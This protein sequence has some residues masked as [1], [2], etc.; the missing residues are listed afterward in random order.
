MPESKDAYIVEGEAASAC[1]AIIVPFHRYGFVYSFESNGFREYSEYLQ[2]KK[3]NIRLLYAAYPSEI[4]ESE[5]LSF[6]GISVSTLVVSE[7][8]CSLGPM[9]S[10]MDRCR[11]VLEW[12]R[13]ESCDAI[14]SSS[15]AGLLYYVQQSKLLNL[16]F[17]RTLI[18][19][20]VT[21]PK[22]LRNELDGTFMSTPADVVEGWLECRTI[23]AADHVIVSSKADCHWLKNKLDKLDPARIT[24]RQDQP[25]IER[26]VQSVAAPDS[27]QPHEFVFIEEAYP[28]NGFNHLIKALLKLDTT[29]LTVNLVL[30]GEPQYNAPLIPNWHKAITDHGVNVRI[31]P[32]PAKESELISYLA[33]GNRT[34]LILTTGGHRSRYGH[35]LARYR[36]RL[37]T[38]DSHYQNTNWPDSHTVVCE[39]SVEALRDALQND[40]L[41]YDNAVDEPIPESADCLVNLP[42]RESEQ[43]NVNG[44]DELEDQRRW[45]LSLIND[46]DINDAKPR[47]SDASDSSIAIAAH[48]VTVCISHYCRPEKL[49]T[50]LS[51]LV[52]QTI[53]GFEVIVVDDGSE[54]E[55]QAALDT[56]IAQFNDRLNIKLIRKENAYLGASRNTGWTNASNAYV[57]FMD[58]DNI[59]C[60]NEIEGFCR[61]MASGNADVLTCF[62]DTFST[63]T[64]NTLTPTVQN[65][66][67]PIG[68]CLAL[69]PIFNCFGDSNSFWKKSVLDN[70]N[71]FTEHRG[72]GKD[73][74]EIFARAA[75]NG[76]S[77][78]VVPFRLFYYRLSED[79]MR[80]FQLIPGASTHRVIEPFTDATSS[81][82]TDLY[83]LLVGQSEHISKIERELKEHKLSCERSQKRFR[84]IKNIL[85]QDAS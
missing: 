27:P 24:V 41:R 77:I 32:F 50:A 62:N 28:R 23:A 37:I 30:L 76:Y 61:A 11:R 52:S 26:M 40:A 67:T 13:L 8:M 65:R 78:E 29:Q 54:V 4:R 42:I 56:V 36:M 49:T 2:Q 68:P 44:A 14:V 80:N 5:N 38:F 66:V 17:G 51:S 53:S 25:E 74:N 73:D 22:S 70:L 12:C 72:V 85:H 21:P 3:Y 79:R 60:P 81:E 58:D 83:S 46:A 18:V 45:F 33:S 55:F 59:A 43:S 10:I 34:G 71:G 31:K 63:T 69:G 82:L 48:D 47:S 64:E 35:L 19:V 75:L 1:V 16:E 7:P 84:I 15:K 20:K 9:S 39:A 6:K 57:L